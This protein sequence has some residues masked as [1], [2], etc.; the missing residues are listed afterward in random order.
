MLSTGIESVKYLNLIYKNLYSLSLVKSVAKDERSYC[1]NNFTKS[2]SIL[3]NGNLID[4][5]VETLINTLINNVDNLL[6]KNQSGG[7]DEVEIPDEFLDPIVFEIMEEPVIL[8]TSNVTLDYSTIKS[9]LLNNNTDPFNRLELKIEDV[10][11]DLELKQRIQNFK[12][13]N[14]FYF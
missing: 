1:K 4:K 11:F 7:K 10:K 13:Q 5:S 9:H 12:N 14:N 6:A 8:P 3:I 2:I